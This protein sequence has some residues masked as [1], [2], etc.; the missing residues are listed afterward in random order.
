MKSVLNDDFKVVME[1]EKRWLFKQLDDRLK[2]IKDPLAQS[3]FK[4][5]QTPSV[6]IV[7]NLLSLFPKLLSKPDELKFVTNFLMVLKES[8]Y[9][10]DC[11]QLAICL[12]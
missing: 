3:S 11:F 12:G 1:N 6:D 8:A 2:L 7:E 9:L 10:R 5:L 4:F